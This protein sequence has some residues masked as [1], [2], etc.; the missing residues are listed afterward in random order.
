MYQVRDEGNKANQWLIE[1]D[2]LRVGKD[3]GIFF[4]VLFVFPIA[5]LNQQGVVED[6]NISEGRNPVN[7]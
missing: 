5:L 3:W 4:V 6:N 7:Y 2:S 1:P